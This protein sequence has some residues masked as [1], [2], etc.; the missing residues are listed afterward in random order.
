MEDSSSLA[1]TQ[2]MSA[3]NWFLIVRLGEYLMLL[4][5]GEKRKSRIAV[6]KKWK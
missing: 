1:T 2:G 4:F 5:I 6:A 3:S